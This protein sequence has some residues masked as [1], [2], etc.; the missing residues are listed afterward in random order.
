MATPLKIVVIGGVAAGPKAAARARR[1]DP[2]A[3]ITLIERGK[4]LSYA[5]CGMPYFIEGKIKEIRDLVSTPAGAPRDTVFF[6]RVK[7]VRVLNRTLV[8]AIDRQ[9]KTVET[10]RVDNNE[11]Q[12]IPYDKLVIATGGLPVVPPI[13][14]IRLNRVF[15]L[16]HPDDAAAIRE[17]LLAGQIKRATIIGGGLIGLEVT[18][19]LAAN[20]VQ[21]SIVEMLE[22]ILPTM[23][24]FE[25]AA[26][27]AKH[28]QAKG[29]QTYTGEK[30]LRLEPD[31]EGNVSRVI[32]NH[33]E[34]D[35]DLV[36]L[37]VGV[38]PNTQLARDAGLEIGPTGGIA[39]NEYLQTSDPDIYA[40]GDC[41]ESHHLVSGQKIHWPMGSA[42]NKH[43]RVIGDNLVGRKTPFSGW[44]KPD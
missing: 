22:T 26:F 28:V 33:R 21:V 42:A 11:H 1:L 44:A 20:G 31:A 12:T 7:D 9:A 6:D 40:G 14:G 5:G 8:L 13:E 30:V 29:V 10:V 34:I 43:G 35:T 15:R 4:L 2:T 41:V 37:A 39:V 17:A 23:L 18:E 19:A 24:D 25:M 16:N 38:R 3:E 36:L 27:L 32:T